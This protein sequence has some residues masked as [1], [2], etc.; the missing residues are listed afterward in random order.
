MERLSGES[1]RSRGGDLIVQPSCGGIVR[2][3]MFSFFLVDSGPCSSHVEHRSTNMRPR[4]V[5]VAMLCQAVA[6]NF[7]E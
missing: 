5:H 7:G 3:D 1:T 6:G 4:K 2:R